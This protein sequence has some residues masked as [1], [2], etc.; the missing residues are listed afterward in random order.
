VREFKLV[1]MLGLTKLNIRS[2]LDLQ[3]YLW[4]RLKDDSHL[5]RIVKEQELLLNMTLFF[6]LEHR[7][8]Y[9]LRAEEMRRIVSSGI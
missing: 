5:R 1:E 2:A 7:F 8:A 4:E 9:D 6:F 3:K